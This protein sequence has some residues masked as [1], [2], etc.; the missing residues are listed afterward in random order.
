MAISNLS[1]QYISSSFQYLM[2]VSSSGEVFSGAGAQ[3]TSLDVNATYATTAGSADAVTGLDT[4]S[5]ATTGSNTFTGNQEIQGNLIVSGDLTAN[6]YI[7][8]STVYAVTQSFSS[9]STIFGNDSV[10]THQF[11]GSLS[12]LGN[13]VATSFTGS[14]LGTATNAAAL[15]NQA[16]SY[17]TN[18]SNINAGTIGDAYLPAT[19]SSDITGNAAT[20][21]SATSASYADTA[22]L[23]T[24]A[25]QA[26][27]VYTLGTDANVTYY[28]AFVASSFSSYNT[29]IVDSGGQFSYNPSTNTLTVPNI[30]GT[31]SFAQTASYVSPTFISASAAA[32]G[33]GTG[34]GGGG[35]TTNSLTITD[36]GG[37]SPGTT[38]DGSSAITIDYSTVGAPKT[39]GT[40]A[41]GAWGIDITGNA[42]SATS[43]SYAVTA[44]YALNAGGG[45]SSIAVSDEG[46]LKTSTATSF[47]FV[48]NAVVANASGGAVTVTIATGSAGG[49]TSPG[50]STDQVQYNSA[51]SFAGTSGLT[52]S[53]SAVVSLTSKQVTPA[54]TYMTISHV[55]EFMAQSITVTAASAR[56]YLVNGHLIH[57][58]NLTSA[59]RGSFIGAGGGAWQTATSATDYS[60]GSLVLCPNPVSS[61]EDDCYLPNS[62]VAINLTYQQ[63]APGPWAT[64]PFH[65]SVIG[66]PLYLDTAG[67]VKTTPTT[68]SGEH[69]RVLGYIYNIWNDS[70]SGDD[71][72]SF[73]FMPAGS[74]VTI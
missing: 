22:S 52:V 20:A 66:S 14:I 46:V 4:G 57:L 42:S 47:N 39:D 41:S 25:Q 55:D 8:N 9:G 34:G 61:G 16:A 73:Y 31:S 59:N 27:S 38:F 15:N 64:I 5:L 23:A 36:S 13:A 58:D 24:N 29:L 37:A 65:P 63:A 51:G 45:G 67:R 26:T 50:G 2:Q 12:V 17:Y 19:I 48:G 60:T 53:S 6:Q 69:V 68:T 32:S 56:V 35:T 62:Y 30:E 54:D 1:T 18:A 10:D 71:Y 70:V 33:F 43:A 21:T 49:T 44:S 72:L 3:V 28:P 11:T 74:W 40:G 7:V